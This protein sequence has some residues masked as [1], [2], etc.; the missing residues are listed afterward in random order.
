MA[1]EKDF[2][3]F[4]AFILKLEGG[5]TENPNDLGNANGSGTMQGIT[6]ATYDSYR[7]S[8][9]QAKKAVKSISDIEIAAIYRDRYWLSNGCNLMPPKLALVVF[10]TS[11]N[12]GAAKVVQYFQELLSSKATGMNAQMINDINYYLSKHSEDDLLFAFIERRKQSYQ[13]FAKKGNQKVFLQ[14][15]LNRLDHIK[16]ELSTW[17]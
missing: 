12:L 7:L 6:Q 16:E 13:A 9:Q 5:Y 17:A 10:D 2:A 3:R 4:L 8:S 15:W 1:T 14:G 11:V